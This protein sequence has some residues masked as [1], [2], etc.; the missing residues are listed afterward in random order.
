MVVE[1]AILSTNPE[2]ERHLAS[3]RRCPIIN[4][5][6][7]HHSVRPCPTAYQ[8]PKLQGHPCLSTLA[9]NQL[10]S[11]VLELG[12]PL[13][14]QRRFSVRAACSR[15]EAKV[16]SA[17]E[18][19]PR[20]RRSISAAPHSL[21]T[22]TSLCLRTRVD[23]CLTTFCQHQPA[24]SHWASADCSNKQAA[25]VHQSQAS[26]HQPQAGLP[27]SCLLVSL[28]VSVNSN[29]VVSQMLVI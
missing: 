21:T 10:T 4:H 6:R 5:I 9:N 16:A 19:R 24:A 2:L 25:S 18:L 13:H 7:H 22:Q 3:D 15:P 26:V 17:L 23:A 14:V 11:S 29:G 12:N 1:L 20:R 28:Q 8:E 27:L